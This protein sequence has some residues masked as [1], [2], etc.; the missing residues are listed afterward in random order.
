MKHPTRRARAQF[1]PDLLFWSVVAL[2]LAAL[3]FRF[4]AYVSRELA[5]AYPFDYDQTKYLWISYSAFERL[6]LAGAGSAVGTLLREAAENGPL[7]HIEALLL[8]LVAG[9]SRLSALSV[10]QVNL[11]AYVILFTG[12]VK[13]VTGSRRMALLATG[14]AFGSGPL[15]FGG[16]IDYR[17]DFSAMC[18]FGLFVSLVMRSDVFHR[19][20]WSLAAGGAAGATILLR[21]LNAPYIAGIYAVML[22]YYG[23]AAMR[24]RSA[25]GARRLTGA[26]ASGLLGAAIVLPF[27]WISRA[28]IYRYYVVRQ[29]LGA[30]PAIQDPVALLLYYPKSL[31]TDHLGLWLPAAAAL[32]IGLSLMGIRWPGAADRPPAR[33]GDHFLFLVV[34]A[35]VVYVSLT[36][37]AA[38]EVVSPTVGGV[39]VPVFSW[40]VALGCWLLLRRRLPSELTTQRAAGAAAAIA[41]GIG[42]WGQTS[43]Y[44]RHTAF[45]LHERDFRPI[46]EM[47]D[48]IGAYSEQARWQA[49]IIAA[50]SMRDYFWAGAVR[51][52][53][54][55]RHG[56]LI[57]FLGVLGASASVN[58]PPRED[59]LSQ[60][61]AAHFLILA[62][63]AGQIEYPYALVPALEAIRPEVERFARARLTRIGQYRILGRTVDL[64]AR[65]ASP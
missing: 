33:L 38:F 21:F 4:R 35:G 50:D 15:W 45:G 46:I 12:G 18:M 48:T 51:V 11:A 31:L 43:H 53:Y 24:R 27:V 6:W 25:D 58:P 52:S 57:G 47:Y 22:A 54:Y 20:G 13:H 49:P 19:L 56:R 59:M 32:A 62:H 30:P 42:L 41:I 44:G 10:H 55:E 3:F 36:A 7:I 34:C 1:W 65:A 5:W 14:L 28:E 8:F 60:L 37:Y 29:G 16:Q 9:P 39:L 63:Q 61:A 40:I 64:Y 26:L 17:L 23:F 2:C